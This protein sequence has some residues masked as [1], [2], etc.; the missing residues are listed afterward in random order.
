VPRC[1][2][3]PRAKAPQGRKKVATAGEAGIE[4]DFDF[5]PE[6]LTKLREPSFLVRSRNKVHKNSTTFS[7]LWCVSMRHFAKLKDLSREYPWYVPIKSWSAFRGKNTGEAG[8]RTL[9]TLL[10]Y[11]AL[12]KRRFRPLSHLTKYGGGKAIAMK[13]WAS[14]E[15]SAFGVWR[16]AFGVWRLAFG[17][18]RSAFG[19]RRQRSA[20][21][22]TDI[23]NT[24]GSGHR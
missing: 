13:P 15:S 14:N 20:G 19:V 8:I 21:E 2:Q 24:Y 4:I 3:R 23:G 10:G 17:V 18:R 16:L 11:N 12:A 22:V 5:Q 6:V 1:R 9:G 7:S